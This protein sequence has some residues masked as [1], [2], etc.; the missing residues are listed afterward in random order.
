MRCLIPGV[1]V[2]EQIEN[3]YGKS[4]DFRILCGNRPKTAPAQTRLTIWQLLCEHT[5]VV[6]LSRGMVV[7]GRFFWLAWNAVTSLKLGNSHAPP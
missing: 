3:F 7:P 1:R 6:P 5:H 2:R 4:N